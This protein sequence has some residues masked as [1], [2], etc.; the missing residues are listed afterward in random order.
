MY[1]VLWK[2]L[3]FNSWTNIKRK[4]VYLFIFSKVAN[5][6]TVL[7]NENHIYMERKYVAEFGRNQRKTVVYVS[8]GWFKV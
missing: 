2:L 1:F 8:K 5:N 3:L 6:K 7:R 4:H